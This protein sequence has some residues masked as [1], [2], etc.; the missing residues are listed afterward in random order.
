MK[1]MNKEEATQA[2]FTTMVLLGPSYKHLDIGIEQCDCCPGCKSHGVTVGPE[3]IAH[4]KE[5]LDSLIEYIR[6]MS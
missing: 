1:A 4:N 2:V 5:E 3:F 6:E